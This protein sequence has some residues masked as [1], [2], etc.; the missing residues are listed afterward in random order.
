M[1]V[2]ADRIAPHCVSW[3]PEVG[4]QPLSFRIC[5]AGLKTPKAYCVEE[6]QR[7]VGV[8]QAVTFLDPYALSDQ[9]TETVVSVFAQASWKTQRTDPA[10]HASR[11]IWVYI[12]R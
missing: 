8:I 5:K 10:I 3:H 7:V 2:G 4:Y 1:P 9:L 11:P 6:F 12:D